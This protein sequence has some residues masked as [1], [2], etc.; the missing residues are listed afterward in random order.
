MPGKL[1]SIK[2]WF[3]NYKRF[4]G[5]KENVILETEEITGYESSKE[6]ILKHNK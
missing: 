4:D 1:L 5:K 3:K 2:N 6:L